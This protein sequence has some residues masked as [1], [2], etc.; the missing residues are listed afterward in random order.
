M[1]DLISTEKPPIYPR[2]AE[3]FGED[4]WDRG[5]VITY[6]EKIHC[7]SGNV[8]PSIIEHEQVHIRQQREYPGGPEAWWNRYLEDPAFRLQEELAGHRAQANYVIMYCPNPKKRLHALTHIRRSISSNYGGIITYQ[9]AC[10][11]I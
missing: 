2:L 10:K 6:G 4:I 11:L 8:A 1:R 9:E 5:V 3:K 7:K